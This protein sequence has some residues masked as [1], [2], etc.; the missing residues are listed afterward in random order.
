MTLGQKDYVPQEVLILI[1]FHEDRTKIKKLLVIVTFKPLRDL[2]ETPSTI[3]PN[4][5]YSLQVAMYFANRERQLDLTT[6]TQP[7]KYRRAKMQCVK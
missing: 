7:I 1:K 3:I 2:L 4:N 5:L 6:I